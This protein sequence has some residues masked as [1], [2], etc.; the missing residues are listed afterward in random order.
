MKRVPEKVRF[1]I[2]NNQI[3]EVS[4]LAIDSISKGKKRQRVECRMGKDGVKRA[5]QGSSFRDWR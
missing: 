4:I 3:I 5:N 2:I 1:Y